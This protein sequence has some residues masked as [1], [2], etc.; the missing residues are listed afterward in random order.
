MARKVWVYDP[1]S[2]GKK[3]PDA[4]K[5]Q[6]RQR[7]LDHA[8]QN[9]AG[10]YNRIDV[11]FR[12][13]FCYIDAYIEPYVAAGFD[14]RPFGESREEFIERLRNTPTHLCRLRYFGNENRWS[15]AFYT[16]SHEK[17]E[18]CI[19]N[20]GSWEGTPEDAFDTAAVYLTD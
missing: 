5:P 19:F 1:Q 6:I 18:P 10:K 9:Y 13:Q 15:M 2:G 14:P 12:G 3:V 4:T 16:Y 20:N 8:E 11:R 7:I 17:Y